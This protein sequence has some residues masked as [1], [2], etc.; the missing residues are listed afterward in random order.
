MS[1]ENDINALLKTFDED[2]QEKRIEEH[3]GSFFR[4]A[5]ENAVM[6]ERA[7][8][9]NDVTKHWV[10]RELWLKTVKKIRQELSRP[11][12]LLTLPGRHRFEIGLYE[13]EKLL[14]R[15]SVDGEE[16]LD[17]VG[18]EYDPTQFGLMMTAEPRLR[19][20]LCGDVLKALVDPKSENGSAI[21]A[22]A[23]YDVIN[24]DLT[25]NIANRNDGPYPPFLKGVREC[26]QLQGSHA[27]PWAMMV[28]FRAGTP[29]TDPSVLETLRE[30]FQQNLEK[31]LKVKE[32][33]IDRYRV[34]TA[35]EVLERHPEEGLAQVTAKWIIEQGHSFEWECRKYRHAA[36][37]RT[38]HEGRKR[39]SLRK[40]VFEFSKRPAP[41]RQ[42]PLRGVP[43]QSWH[44]DDLAKL[45][46]QAALVDVDEVMK[47]MQA[48][49][50]AFLEKEI[51]ELSGEGTTTD[52]ASTHPLGRAT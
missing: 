18:F 52:S 43:E 47:N 38:F 48:D 7:R 15:T 37:D 4:N 24:L 42:L 28:T 41:N 31:H 26:F 3:E 2:A 46:E 45:F 49:K 32:H 14:A 11:L 16:R 44:A 20:L 36:Y 17:V 5:P 35:K 23:P 27:G 40:L 25:T 21:R 51:A 10:R 1:T 33:C 8:E 29:E 13:K 22:C 9:F 34:S 6:I 12:R 30:F 19:E 39:Y 50:R